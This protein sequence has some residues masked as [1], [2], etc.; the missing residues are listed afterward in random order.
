MGGNVSSVSLGRRR[1]NTLAR[2]FLTFYDRLAVIDNA[3][4][5]LGELESCLRSRFSE[6]ELRVVGSVARF[7][8]RR[9][10][11]GP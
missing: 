5:S 9:G 1:T 7:I 10:R 3:G 6:F 8:G 11:T 2:A 4:V